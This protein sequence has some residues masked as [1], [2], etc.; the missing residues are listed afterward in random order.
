ME[1]LQIEKT[2]VQHEERRKTL[3]EETK[4]NNQV[5]RI[6][7]IFVLKE[8]HILNKTKIF[9]RAHILITKTESKIKF[10][11]FSFLVVCTLFFWTRG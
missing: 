6:H 1:K 5:S 8:S 4:Q 2:R 11:F 10:S 3:T 9:F 7:F